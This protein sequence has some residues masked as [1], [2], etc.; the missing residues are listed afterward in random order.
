MDDILAIMLA[1]AAKPEEI[2]LLL[3]SVTYGNVEAQRYPAISN[4]RSARLMFRE[5]V[6]EMSLHCSILLKESW[7]G[8]GRK[9]CQKDLM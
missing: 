5:A 2:D 6:Y 9:D 8:E 3:I 4:F 7:N 1:L